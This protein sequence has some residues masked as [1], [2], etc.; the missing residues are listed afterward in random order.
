[1]KKIAEGEL[2]DPYYQL[3]FELVQQMEL[4]AHNVLDYSGCYYESDTPSINT[5]Y[6]Q[7]ELER[8]LRAKGVLNR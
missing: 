8:A 3:A 5:D 7:K 2:L 1:M 6:I 4:F